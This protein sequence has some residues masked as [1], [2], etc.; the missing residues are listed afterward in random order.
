MLHKI[1]KAY[2]IFYLK[3]KVTRSKMNI[4]NVLIN[5]F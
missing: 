4:N 1:I 2:I 5:Y 3:E